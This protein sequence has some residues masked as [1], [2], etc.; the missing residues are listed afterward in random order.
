[1]TERHRWPSVSV[2]R[3][4]ASRR[5]ALLLGLAALLVLGMSPVFGHHL[6]IRIDAALAGR[7]HLW[8]LCLMALK[9]VMGPVHGA[10]HLLFFAGLAY[11]M[12]DRVRAWRTQRAVLE[13]VAA[14]EPVS[15]SALSRAVSA[16]GLEPTRVLV[17]KGQPTPA[18]T[19][20][21]LRPRVY[22]AA[23]LPEHLSDAE[24]A[25]VLAHEAEHVRR[26]DPLRLFVLRFLGCLL[27]WLPAM[28]RV[29]ADYAAENEIRADDAAA[30]RH[31]L[32]L[33]S[34]LIRLAD[35]KAPVP[36]AASAGFNGGDLL[37]RRVLRLTGEEVPPR[38]RL[39]RRSLVGATAVLLLAWTS[40][41]AVAHA[42]PDHEAH[43]D[44]RDRA[45]V[46]HLFCANSR[47]HEIA[48]DCP[49]RPQP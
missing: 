29:A 15:G 17:V 46:F 19:T 45:A 36:A 35:W 38:S 8:A 30:D 6:P 28:R 2:R 34:A 4:E 7:D 42:L 25:A 40:G 20:G 27:F 21:W 5:R 16:A 41:V 31:G 23:A 32:A 18:F 13:S 14:E 1:M 43:C 44:Q 22:V 47:S 3:Q 24:L 49:H 9:A 12:Q 39:T 11:A 33:A 26:R 48:E 37:E 10:F